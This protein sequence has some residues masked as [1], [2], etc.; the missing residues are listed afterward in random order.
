[1]SNRASTTGTQQAYHSQTD[2]DGSPQSVVR[3]LSPAMS[4][5]GSQTGGGGT[6]LLRR[7]I[8][9]PQNADRPTGDELT[10]YMGAVERHIDRMEFL[11]DFL[12]DSRDDRPPKPSSVATGQTPMAIWRCAQAISEEMALY[13][14]Y[15]DSIKIQTAQIENQGLRQASAVIQP[16]SGGGSFKTPLPTK[17][18]GKKG[19][20]ADTFLVACNN[21][22][23]MRPNAFID[24]AQFIRWT[25]QQMEGNAGPWKI[26]QVRRMD[27]EL[28]D[29]GNPPPELRRWEDF[30]KFFLI[31]FGDPG[32]VEKARVKWKDGLDQTGKAVDYFEEIESLLLRLDYPR[33]SQMT[34]DQVIAGLKP[35]IR[36]HFI[37]KTWTSLNDM[38]AEVVPY[39]SA[40]WEINKNRTTA[41]KTQ[42]STSRATTTQ[43]GKERTPTP[44]KVETSK[45]G[46]TNRRFLPQDEFEQC[47]KNQWCFMC[48]ANGME[49]VGSAKFHPNHLPQNTTKNKDK[50]TKTTKIAATDGTEQVSC[51]DVT[52]EDDYEKSKN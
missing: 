11:L 8:F 26:R 1:M 33:D 12:G 2:T 6:N 10:A 41:N 32:L 16:Q 4:Q 31:Q 18:E 24:E 29:Q 19:D 7:P 23:V 36:T 51:A 50:D 3:V 35:H 15:V 9:D 47:K 44:I 52:S 34:L 21:Y 30:A 5:A 38:K 28:D 14:K 25:L 48:K 13:E 49:I 43:Q 27:T 42:A 37:G 22:R 39:D 20:S 46:G 45:V 40:F 17:Y